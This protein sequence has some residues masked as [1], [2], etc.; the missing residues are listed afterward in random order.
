MD[1]KAY[2]IGFN[3]VKGVG[4][5]RLQGLLDFFGNLEMAWNAPYDALRQA[6]LSEKIVEQFLILRKQ[7]DLSRIMERI[8]Q[9]GIRVFTWSDED[10][11]R[12]LREIDQSPP[13]L[14]CKGTIE[15]EDEWAVAVVGTRRIS[16][17]GRQVT[18]ELSAFLARRGVTVVSGLARGV[19]AL[20]HQT[21]IQNGGRTFA[22]LGSGVDKI[23]PPEHRKLAQE[24]SERGA[25]ISDYAPGT[26]PDG[27]NFP[28]RNRI[29]SGLTL[30]TVV[31]EAGETSGALI[32]ANFAAN[33]G[34]DVFAVPGS[35][36]APQSIGANRLIQDGARPLLKMDDVLESLNLQNIFEKQTARRVLPG[37]EVEARLLKCLSREPLHIDE[38]SAN[39]GLSI[40]KVSAT[41][42]MMELKGMVQ[43]VGG[44]NYV[45]IQEPNEDYRTVNHA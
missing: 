8:D 21:A 9:A 19:D 6:G 30:A 20:A 35:I 29:I 18:Q 31:I 37:D 5:V 22:V 12:R 27:S 33:Q 40:D 2:W 28:P 39:S 34:R 13:V 4:A 10:Y 1:E 38:I 32:T 42:V 26:P 36:Y 44:M 45:S 15:P 11:P 17:Y 3:L 24:I 41:L 14:Y 23:Y 43:Q 7:V 16:A 25:V